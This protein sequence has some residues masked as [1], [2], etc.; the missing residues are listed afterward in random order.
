M[1][2]AGDRFV[3]AGDNGR[4]A[5]T[6][7]GTQWDIDQVLGIGGLRQ[8]TA[9]GGSIVAAGENGWVAT[10][11]DGGQNWSSQQVGSTNHRGVVF[12]TDTFFLGGG[13]SVYSSTD[14]LVWQ[15]VNGSSTTPM[16][17]F[18]RYLFGMSSNDMV[19]MRSEDGGFSWTTMYT[20]TGGFPL[21]HAAMES[22]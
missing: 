18:G 2:F 1:T 9:G 13:G 17:A 22:P 15:L 7:D 5:V 6:L 21:G 16:A 11:S 4:V 3:A 8:I 10:S 12:N 20:S 19:M 14:G